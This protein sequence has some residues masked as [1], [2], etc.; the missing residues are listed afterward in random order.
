MEY[1][2][3]G[4]TDIDVSTVSMGCW[5]IVGGDWWGPQDEADALA[6]INTALEVGI[7]FSIVP[8]VTAQVHR[9]N[10]W[11]A[12]SAAGALRSSSLRKSAVRI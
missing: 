7:N 3:L 5:A 4:Q 2:K 9:K 12:Y 6:A 10:Y 11:G 8:K 1:R